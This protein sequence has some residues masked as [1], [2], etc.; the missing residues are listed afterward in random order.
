M[1]AVIE[2]GKVG[3]VIWVSAVAGIG[4]TALFSLIV[5]SGSRSAEC[6][7][8]GNGNGTLYGAIS[9]VSLVVFLAVVIIGLTVAL[10]KS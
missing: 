10:K 5:Y 3:E 8:T 1:L 7:R 6:R 2:W 4:A 9:V